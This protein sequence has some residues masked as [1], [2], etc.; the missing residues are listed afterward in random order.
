MAKRHFDKNRHPKLDEIST[1]INTYFTNLISDYE[2]Y[3][4][5]ICEKYNNGL[6]FSLF[7][8]REED[9][10]ALRLS[11]TDSPAKNIR[12]E[13]IY[14][15]GSQAPQMPDNYKI[16]NHDLDLK[17][18]T[19]IHNHDFSPETIDA[20]NEVLKY[21]LNDKPSSKNPKE[22]Y[23]DTTIEGPENPLTEPYFQ[24]Y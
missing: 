8:P 15:V 20:I 4:T 13:S 12:L 7:N 1:E 9:I 21:I 3:S 2:K 6:N 24:I 18:V 17:L 16:G 11:Q 14:V 5:E 10:L 22:F 23:I 19:D